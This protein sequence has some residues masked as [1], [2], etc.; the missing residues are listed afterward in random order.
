[1]A[2]LRAALLVRGY[3]SLGGM[4]F[5]MPLFAI[6]MLAFECQRNSTIRRI[7]NARWVALPALACLALG[8]VSAPT[9]YGIAQLPLYG[10]FFIAV[11]CGNDLVG[12]LRTRGALL[13]GEC[14]YGIYLLHGTVLSLLF[15]DC[16]SLIRPIATERLPLLI[17]VVALVVVCITP[18]VY[19][20]I[21]RPAI[22]A[23]HLIARRWLERHPRAD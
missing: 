7:F 14:S 1:M 16:E 21:E 4:A 10:C 12:V 23:G 22:R 11:A 8:M 9:P 5:Y 20:A 13:L 15:V 19:L 3:H 18:V 2:L 6:G 17:P